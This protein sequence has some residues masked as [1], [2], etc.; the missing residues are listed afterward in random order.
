MVDYTDTS[1]SD[2]IINKLTY[3]K[4]M[5]LK[6]AGTLQADQL[7]EITDPNSIGGSTTWGN[8]GG[9]LSNQTDL[10]TALSGKQATLVSGTSIKTVNST[11]LLGSGDIAVQATLVSGT[12]IKT[13]NN[14]SL[15]GSGDVAVQAS[16]TGGATSITSSNLTASRALISNSSGKVAVSDVTSTELSYLDGVTSAV[17]TQLDGKQVTLVSGTNIKTVN[18]NSL[19]GSGNV[20]ISATGGVPTGTIMPYGGSTA[21]DGYLLCDGS[22]VSR[23]TY[24]ALYAV[25]GTTYGSGDGNSTFNLPNLLFILQGIKGT[26]KTLGLTNGS[27]LLGI[28][29]LTSSEGVSAAGAFAELDIGANVPSSSNP[30][31]KIYGIT[32]N[33]TKSGIISEIDINI[34]YMIK[35]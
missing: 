8:I 10:N 35:Y 32:T 23:T 12:N 34:K 25:I 4:Y 2:L 1:V 26:G 22:A 5:E 33:S 30:T 18:G 7:Y 21:P 31:R 3:A 17:Q 13:I 15:L 28:T 11:S 24:S 9:T 6:N 14:T 27:I 20:T 16:I 19:L 29:R